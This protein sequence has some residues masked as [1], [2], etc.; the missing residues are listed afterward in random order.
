MANVNSLLD[1]HVVLR[2]ESVDRLILNGYVPRL[3]TADG[4]ALFLRGQPGE[5]IPRYAILGERTV[6]LNRAI[7]RFAET[8]G[9]PLV[10]FE[11]GQR[12]EAI[13]AP[14]LAAAEAAGRPG[15]VLIGLAQE[16]A[17]VFRPPAVRDRVPGRYAARRTSAFVNHVYFYLFDV[18]PVRRRGRAGLHQALHVCAV[19]PPGMV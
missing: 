14:H 18:L 12:K 11:K 9:I 1:D 7:E 13:A 3:Q 16:R 8:N 15:V 2:Y 17:S 6:S 10:H 19:E 5:E 4:L